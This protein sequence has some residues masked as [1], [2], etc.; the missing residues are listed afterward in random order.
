[1]A[2]KRKL[3]VSSLV[4]FRNPTT[5][6]RRAN[7]QATQVNWVTMAANNSDHQAQNKGILSKRLHT[8]SSFEVRQ[9]PDFDGGMVTTL[10]A[11]VQ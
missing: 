1:M 5:K 4:M 11:E 3:R 9:L 6:P 10:P 2:A 7:T 8:L